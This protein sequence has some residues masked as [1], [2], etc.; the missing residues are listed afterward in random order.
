MG[1]GGAPKLGKGGKAPKPDGDDSGSEELEE[2]VSKGVAN[3]NVGGAAPA[4][5]TFN[6]AGKNQTPAAAGGFTFAASGAAPAFNFP[7]VGLFP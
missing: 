5:F 7:T 6:P 2:V 4:P 3:M 1:F